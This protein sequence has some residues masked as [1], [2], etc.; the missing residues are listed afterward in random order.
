MVADTL[1]MPRRRPSAVTREAA[2]PCCGSCPIL[3]V[4]NGRSRCPVRRVTVLP[5]Q[6]CLLRAEERAALVTLLAA[7]LGVARGG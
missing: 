1:P 7:H 2:P 6:V 5:R 3:D 4:L